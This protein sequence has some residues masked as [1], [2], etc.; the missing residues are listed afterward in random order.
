MLGDEHP[1]GHIVEQ[2]GDVSAIRLP[3]VQW[4][5]Q[6]YYRPDNATLTA[7]GGFDPARLRAEI[8][9]YFGPI[10]STGP[11]G[12]RRPRRSTSTAT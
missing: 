5:F 8:E 6:R 10:R 2:E 1:Y 7:I 4:F 9:R 12:P 11:A 3:H